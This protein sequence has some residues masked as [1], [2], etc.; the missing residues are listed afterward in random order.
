LRRVVAL[1][2]ATFAGACASHEVRYSGA[3]TPE[4]ACGAAEHA[5]LMVIEGNAS[6]AANDGA[7]VVPAT[8]A[9]GGKLTG[10]LV[11]TGGDK[12]PFPLTLDGVV[13]EQS[14]TGT[15]STPR[16]R[17]ALSLKR[18]RLGLFGSAGP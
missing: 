13:T 16:C 14:A 1:G 10:S 3:M 15:Y 2:L 11:L 9:P 7:V 8:V 17:F 4:S 5:T 12:K 6:F 18:V